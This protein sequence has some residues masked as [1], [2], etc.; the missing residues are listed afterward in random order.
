MILEVGRGRK[1]GEIMSSRLVKT[2]SHTRPGNL[3]FGMSEPIPK[4][5]DVHLSSIMLIFN[6]KLIYI[7]L[8]CMS[9]QKG[10]KFFPFMR[11]NTSKNEIRAGYA[12]AG[13]LICVISIS[14][15]KPKTSVSGVFAGPSI[16][17]GNEVSRVL[18]PPSGNQYRGIY[19]G[20]NKNL[21]QMFPFMVLFF[22]LMG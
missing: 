11:G 14:R 3:F 5:K 7:D 16:F 18:S 1:E 17:T 12:E 21:A 20:R 10:R 9:L 19:S 6:Q 4:G 8:L 22:L 15:K 13:I 2:T